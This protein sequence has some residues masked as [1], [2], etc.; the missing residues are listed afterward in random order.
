MQ[1]LAGKHI[2]LGV[3]GSIAAYKAADLTSKLVQEGAL[4]DVVL[5]DA[6]QQF[7]TSFTFRS[8][9]GRPV[10]TNLFEP[11]TEVAEEHVALARRADLVLVAPAT[12][13]TLARLV[14]GLGDDL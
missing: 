6:A 4:V 14:Y 10:F 1:P 13:T 5:T 2:V 7:V 11:A 9:T 8:L 3:T 12:A